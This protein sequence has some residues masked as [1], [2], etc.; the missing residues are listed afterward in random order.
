MKCVCRD[1]FIRHP[2]PREQPSSFISYEWENLFKCIHF[3][4]TDMEMKHF[5]HIMGCIGKVF[6]QKCH[7]IVR[8]FTY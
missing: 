4:K 8:S 3:L 6:S 7:M 1:V 5:H 2:N